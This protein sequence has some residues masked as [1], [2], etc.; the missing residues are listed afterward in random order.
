MLCHTLTTALAVGS[1][2]FNLLVIAAVCIMSVPEGE[3]KSVTDFGVFA[4]TAIFS[5]WAY[6]WMLI[7]Y[8]I[9][10]PDQVTI[11]EAVLTLAYLPLMVLCAYKINTRA[12]GSGGADEPAGG[13]KE[14]EEGCGA[15]D[16]M[17]SC[18]TNQYCAAGL[19]CSGSTSSHC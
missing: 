7:V 3:T 5:L 16:L 6:L 2:A 9:W 17:R 14:D 13:R 18:D 15:N 1:A 19:E 11:I 10:T 4:F 12:G 8:V